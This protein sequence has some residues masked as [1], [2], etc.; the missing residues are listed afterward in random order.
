MK[1]HAV[2]MLS[3]YPFNRIALHTDVA[4]KGSCYLFPGL[5]HS[6]QDAKGVCETSNSHL[7]VLND[8]LPPHPRP[9][10]VSYLGELGERAWIGMSGAAADDGSVTF[11]WVNGEA[12]EFTNWA[13][14]E[15][16]E[17]GGSS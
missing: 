13:E 9:G 2:Y 14:Y 11:S 16:G 12:V 5:T 17:E 4:Y 10:A 1:R 15:P 3:E 7:V 8:R 6:W